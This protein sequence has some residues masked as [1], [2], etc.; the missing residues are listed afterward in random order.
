MEKSSFITSV[1]KITDRLNLNCRHNLWFA[2]YN[3]ENKSM[4]IIWYDNEVIA[5]IIYSNNE[6]GLYK[7][8]K[9]FESLKI[10]ES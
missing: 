9:Y 10:I 4:S 8:E 5:E 6:A 7:I 2:T 3:L 1:W